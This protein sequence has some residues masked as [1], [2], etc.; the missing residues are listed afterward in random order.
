MEQFFKKEE[1]N[2]EASN[3]LSNFPH[4]FIEIKVHVSK[5]S[6]NIF[7]NPSF[8]STLYHLSLII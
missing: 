2:E 6:V 8:S 1:E 4:H 5:N 3:S 7:G